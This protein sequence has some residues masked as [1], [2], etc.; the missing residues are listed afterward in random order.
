VLQATYYGASDY[1]AVAIAIHPPTG[2]V[3]FGGRAGALGLVV[4]IDATLT[5]VHGVATFGGSAT[6]VTAIA[7]HPPSGD[8]IVGGVTDYASLECTKSNG[9]CANGAQPDKADGTDGFLMRLPA[10]LVGIRQATYLGTGGDDVITA[11]F[12]HPVS[13]EV[14]AA[15]FGSVGDYDGFIALLSA[16]LR[17]LIRSNG[18]TGQSNDFARAMTLHPNGE[19]YVAGDTLSPTLP[20]SQNGAQANNA[21][22]SDGFIARFG[23]DPFTVPQMTFFGGSLD[24]TVNALAVHPTTGDVYIAGST[25]STNLPCV[26][27]GS[28][29]G[30]GARTTKS[31]SSD[32][33]VARFTPDLTF[34]DKTPNP[35]A[36]APIVGAALS[37]LQTSS[38]VQV[39]GIAG[40]VA[41]Y[42]E[43]NA[44]STYCISTSNACTCDVNDF[45]ASEPGTMSNNQY[46]CVRHASAP[47]PNEVTRTVFH[48]GGG[49]ATFRVVTG[50]PFGGCSLD[51]DGNTIID[52][53]TD[54]LMLL[55]AMFGL[56]GTSVT[57][58][59]VGPGA[60]RSTWAQVRSYLNG[61]CA[62]SFAQ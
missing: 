5:N 56:T 8:V 38:P 2:E 51:I 54:G 50:A 24:E 4:I 7:V 32:G 16:N 45:F 60:T 46:V 37:T 28:G 18:I 36:F 52:A 39:T 34:A 57:S 15:G 22:G 31:G 55:R 26:I 30:T 19:I 47:V 29:C 9:S 48:A 58:N 53:L 12:V 10:D 11:L 62:T 44:A 6:T 25:T 27:A 3:L 14:Y 49:A 17:L 33:F 35:F 59:A 13:G 61:N 1:V 20:V 43:G 21:G 23:T 42:V 40:P 41:V